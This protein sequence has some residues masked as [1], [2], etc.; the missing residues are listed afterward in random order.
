MDEEQELYKD[1]SNVNDWSPKRYEHVT[2][3]R[4]NGL[5]K[6]REDWADYLF[7]STELTLGWSV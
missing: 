4:Q 3:L 7:V 6:A 5:K 2:R 1:A